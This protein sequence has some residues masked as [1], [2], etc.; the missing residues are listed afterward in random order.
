VELKMCP[1]PWAIPAE[2]VLYLQPDPTGFTALVGVSDRWLRQ[3]ALTIAPELRH[4]DWGSYFFH[5]Y[6]LSTKTEDRWLF[7]HKE[8]LTAAGNVVPFE[9]IEVRM[10]DTL[11]YVPEHGF[12]IERGDFEAMAPSM[13]VHESEL[14]FLG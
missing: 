10:C 5:T 12:G 14:G 1:L 2:R 11:W 3:I 9:A 7:V 8:S 13:K 4:Y 6:T